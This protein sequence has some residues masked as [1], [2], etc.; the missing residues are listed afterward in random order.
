VKRAESIAEKIQHF[1]DNLKID[2]QAEIAEWFKN[3]TK[4]VNRD[5]WNLKSD[6]KNAHFIGSYGRGTAI[7]GINN[8]NMLVVLPDKIYKQYD[9]SPYNGQFSLINKV[10]ECVAKVYP[11]AY[12]NEEGHL[13]IDLPNKIIFEVVPTFLN[14]KKNYIY[15]EPAEGGYWK[16]F[17]PIKEISVMD[18]YNFEYNG[19]IKHLAKM[20]RAWK[21]TNEVPMSGML[22]D[23][24]VL[25]FMEEWEGNQTS[26]SYYGNMIQDFLEYLA[27]R[28]KDQ[29]HWYAKG[30]NRQLPAPQDFG[31]KANEA[32][33]IARQALTLENDLDSAGANKCWQKIFGDLFPSS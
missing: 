22:L 31:Y 8:I 2:N 10:K 28:R 30:S 26:Y 3:I 4:Q 29:L 32:F 19:K 15:P 20:M 7:K 21:K 27:G 14:A 17:N 12:I 24:L 11:T 25:N 9:A 18:K 16:V 1:L 33:K 5:F 23:T 13:L 6:A